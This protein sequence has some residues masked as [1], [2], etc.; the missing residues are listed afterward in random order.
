MTT[1]GHV[2]SGGYGDA[3]FERVKPANAPE[4]FFKEG[5]ILFE[6]TRVGLT[7]L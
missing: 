3:L 1:V 4:F 2:G 6:N 5:A 7:V